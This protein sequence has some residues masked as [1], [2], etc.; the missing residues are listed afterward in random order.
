MV[1]RASGVA[2]AKADPYAML[3]RLDSRTIPAQKGSPMCD[4]ITGG[5]FPIA[6]LCL[7]LAVLVPGEVTA[8]PQFAAHLQDGTVRYAHA[9]V[10]CAFGKC[11]WNDVGAGRPVS[12]P[13]HQVD[14]S[15]TPTR[16]AGN[17]ARQGSFTFASAAWGGSPHQDLGESVR[18]RRGSAREPEL[19]RVQHVYQ[20]QP[21]YVP[22]KEQQPR[23]AELTVGRVSDCSLHGTTLSETSGEPSWPS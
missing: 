8:E 11:V 17:P 6:I 18:V 16:R 4:V 5:A 3:G 2:E 10:T 7:L 14:L 21:V 1:P 19:V 9:P 13:A 23:G 22:V 15:R 20:V 12:V